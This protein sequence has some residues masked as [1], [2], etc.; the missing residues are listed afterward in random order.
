M[1][2]GIESETVEFKKSTGEL[3]EGI[4]SI[5]SMLNKND[6]AILYFGVLNDGNIIGQDVNEQTLRRIS[7]E[8]ADKIIPK[9]TPTITLLNANNKAYIKVEVEGKDKPYS[10]YGRYYIRSFDED[11]NLEQH[12]LFDMLMNYSNKDLITIIR[13]DKQKLSFRTLKNLY[14]DKKIIINEDE[15]E[16][17]LGLYNLNGEYNYMAYLLADNNEVSIKVVTFAGE[18]KT[19]MI[20]RNEYGN[21]CLM[22]AIEQVL[23]YIESVNDTKVT[24][25]AY[26]RIDEQLF[27]IN[28]FKEA[29]M[30]ACLHSRWDRRVPPIVYIYSNRIEIV[31]SGGLPYNLSKERFYKGTSRPV[32]EKL[33][34]IFGQLR[35][36]E[37][38]GHGV[39]IIVNK[40]GKEAFDIENDF[41]VVTI[42]FSRPLLN[43]ENI[44]DSIVLNKNQEKL[45]NYLREN[46]EASISD[47][48]KHLKVSEIYIK[49]MIS[50]LK[51]LEYIERVGSNR[52]GYWR[53]LK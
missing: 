52:E 30:N 29:W 12:Q 28:C 17:N 6:K 25:N 18:D 20:R 32:N 24:I 19:V 31:S 14:I 27:D 15:F 16:N 44:Q 37:Q 7:R 26:T 33:Q 38:T 46:S 3:K 2:L 40:Y 51:K 43:K 10:A 48:S 50:D 34:K 49:K 42:P 35:Y 5:S 22:L 8:I 53:V 9:I 41:I 1:N 45:L 4:I 21:K 36:V 13:S 39:P 23:N 11:R 47:L